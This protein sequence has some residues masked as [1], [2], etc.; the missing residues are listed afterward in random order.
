MHFH[1]HKDNVQSHPENHQTYFFRIFI[2][3]FISNPTKRRTFASVAILA[4]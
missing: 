3:L 4:I 1:A 2:G